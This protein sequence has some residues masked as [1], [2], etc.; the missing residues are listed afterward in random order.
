M[1]KVSPI[2]L[3]DENKS[4]AGFNLRHLLF[5]QNKVDYVSGVLTK[6]FDLWK[7]SKITPVIDS[8]WALEDVSISYRDFLFSGISN[9]IFQNRWPGDSQV[10]F[11][12]EDVAR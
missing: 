8:E 3:F 5:Q 1:D 10:F 11:W 6:I 9:E 2:K 4:I 12:R 7:A